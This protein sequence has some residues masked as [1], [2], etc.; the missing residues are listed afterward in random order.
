MQRELFSASARR[1]ALSRRPRICAASQMTATFASAVRA[2]NASSRSCFE[3]TGFDHARDL[4]FAV[5]RVV[6]W[7][8]SSATATESAAAVLHDR[9]P[10][11]SRL[12]QLLVNSGMARPPHER[13]RDAR[14]ALS[15]ALGARLPWSGGAHAGPGGSTA[16]SSKWPAAPDMSAWFEL[17][18][19]IRP[20]CSERA[21]DFSTKVATPWPARRRR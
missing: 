16:R 20:I 21:A 5:A 9:A 8:Q 19:R 10:H 7:W 1:V 12:D 18:A 4:G 6:R 11:A 2:S 17:E 13:A 14:Q 3:R 15:I